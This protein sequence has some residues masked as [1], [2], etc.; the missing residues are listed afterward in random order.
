MKYLSF[1]THIRGHTGDFRNEMADQLAKEAAG[2]FDNDGDSDASYDS[3]DYGYY[4]GGPDF[5]RCDCH[6]YY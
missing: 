2:Y 3:C 1:Q 4:C 5:C 6:H